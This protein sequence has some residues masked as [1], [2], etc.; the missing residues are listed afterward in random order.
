M[1]YI[2]RRLGFYLI[3]L[4]AALTIN[5][6][7]PRMLPGDPASTILGANPNMQPAQIEALRQALG[8]T[9][10][11]LLGQYFTY[12][13]H[14]IR[15]EFGVSYSFFPAPVTAVISNGLIWTLMLGVIS[16][17]IAFLLGNLLGVIGAWRR[18]GALDTTV[19][20]LLIFFG[21]FPPF[22]LALAALF[23][24]GL[25]LGWFPTSHAYDDSLH[26]GFSPQ[27][28]GSVAQH[29][30]L[31]A[32]VIVLV[33]IGGWA[34]GM[35][36]VMVGVLA[37]DYITM[38][39]AKGLKQNRIM[40]WYAARNAL[41]PG[42]TGFGIALGFVLSGQI[43]IEQVFAYPGLGFLLVQ[44][45]GSRDYPLMQGLF[46]MI[47]IAVLAANFIVDIFYTR[48]DPRVRAG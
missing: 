5:F 28:I 2:L 47:T 23:L 45:V 20:P 44:A 33:S 12:L 7:L 9:N 13:T 35:R 25:T 17:L 1:N 42:I 16:L 26:P 46:L 15:G 37:E 6:F 10:D 32:L 40:F 22:F 21:A 27:F 34:L 41:L 14:A 30:F 8:F 38:A 19:P 29:M 31:P 39:E 24:L 43:L 11:N 3:A 36:N 18:G 48:L 4:W